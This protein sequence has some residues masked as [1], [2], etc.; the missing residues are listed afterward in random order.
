MLARAVS[1]CVSAV[2]VCSGAD[3]AAEAAVIAHPVGIGFALRWRPQGPVHEHVDRCT[4]DGCVCVCVRMHAC[5]HACMHAAYIHTN[6]YKHAGT[7]K[8]ICVLCKY[9][10]ACTHACMHVCVQTYTHTYRHAFGPHPHKH[11][12][13]C[14]RG[15]TRTHTTLTIRC[16]GDA[17]HSSPFD[18]LPRGGMSLTQSWTNTHTCVCLYA[19]LS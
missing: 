9:M 6:T 14:A 2:A 3:I 17:C 5:M 7:H 4:A 16:S 19:C 13:A 18:F 15:Y 11:K 12:C 1:L 10:Y 8:C